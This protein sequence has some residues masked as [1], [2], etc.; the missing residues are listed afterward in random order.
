MSANEMDATAPPVPEATL[1]PETTL[2]RGALRETAGLE[3]G[4]LHLVSREPLG[5]GAIAGFRTFDTPVA[6]E[7]AREL[8]YYVDTSRLPVAHETGLAL[9][10]PAEP[11]ARIWLHPAD[12]HLPA[13]APAAFGDAAATLLARINIHGTALPE[14]VAYRPGRRA[15]LRV[16]HDRGTAWVKIVR[17][18]RVGRI[19]GIHEA[20][21][22]H[23]LPTPEV[24]AWSPEGLMVLDAA[25]G[26]PADAQD[27]TAVL[28]NPAALLDA[29]DELRTRLAAAPLDVPARES[30]STQHDW[31]ASRLALSLDA[32]STLQRLAAATSARAAAEL[33]AAPLPVDGASITVH[34]D[35]HVGQIFLGP[36]GTVSS[37]ID[38][39]TAGKGDPAEDSAAFIAHALASV[40]MAAETPGQSVTRWDALAREARARWMPGAPRV[41]PLTAIQLLAHALGASE[42]GLRSRAEHLI[43]AAAEVVDVRLDGDADV[44]AVVG[45]ATADPAL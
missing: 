42:L 8:V 14:L 26:V 3:V 21:H 29:I 41:R 10:D 27:D 32:G 5:R 36:D 20:L 15:V 38:L 40:A 28:G 35:L 1:L 45:A 6:E 11:D 43:A 25:V 18:S 4:E 9:G 2:L 37:L 17:P 30:L 31:Y 7:P 16:P 22:A 44:A 24:L 13:L 23:G 19:A 12:P 34:G 33:E 39:D